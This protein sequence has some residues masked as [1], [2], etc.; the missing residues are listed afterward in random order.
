VP[1]TRHRCSLSGRWAE[2]DHGQLRLFANQVRARG[3]RRTQATGA[4]QTA[5]LGAR[6]DPEDKSTQCPRKG[7]VEKKRG[8]KTAGRRQRACLFGNARRPGRMNA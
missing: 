8:C 6:R 2:H 1:W 7:C 5:E 4:G 3:I